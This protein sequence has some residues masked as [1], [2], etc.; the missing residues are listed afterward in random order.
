[1]IARHRERKTFL[2]QICADERRYKTLSHRRVEKTGSDGSADAET[3][4][5]EWNLSKGN[6]GHRG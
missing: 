6:D 1:V 4:A 5:A 3:G 2:P